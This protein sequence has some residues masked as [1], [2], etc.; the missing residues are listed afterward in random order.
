MKEI[1]K[2]QAALVAAQ[3]AIA[4]DTSTKEYIKIQKTLAKANGY[5]Y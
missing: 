1:T 2:E 3:A 5:T 4:A